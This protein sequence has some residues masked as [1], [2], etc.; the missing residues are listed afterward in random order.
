[1][2]QA[3][4]NLLGGRR[5][6][7]PVF[8]DVIRGF[9]EEGLGQPSPRAVTDVHTDALQTAVVKAYNENNA[10]ICQSSATC[11]REL[12]R[13]RLRFSVLRSA[14]AQAAQSAS[15]NASNRSS[16]LLKPG[17]LNS[18]EIRDLDRRLS[19]HHQNC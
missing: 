11:R 4:L 6:A 13:V 17:I 15:T 9:Y 5:L 1:L 12:P 3:L 18:N 10:P 2:A 14:Q 8:I 19:G 16:N 7:A